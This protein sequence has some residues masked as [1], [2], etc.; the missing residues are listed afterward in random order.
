MGASLACLSAFLAPLLDGCI[1]TN[2]PGDLA[3]RSVE[4][5]DW[6]DQAELPGPGASPVLGMVSNRDLIAKGQSLT[7]GE[8]WHRPL[9]KIEFTST[10][11]LSKFVV[12]NSYNLG[13]ETFLC[14]HQPRSPF[15]GYPFVYWHGVRLGEHETDPIEQHGEP[16]KAS[17]TYYVFVDVA[18]EARPQDIPPQDGF[19]LRQKPTDVCLYVRG[20]NESGRGYRSNTMVVPKDAIATVLQKVPRGSGG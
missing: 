11:D 14:D 8:K 4:V 13:T 2:T 9:L 18:R 10:T 5:V 3:F 17:I 20:G 7:G 12:D 15:V 16:G 6:K 1:S 19:D